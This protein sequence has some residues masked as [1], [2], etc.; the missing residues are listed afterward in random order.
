MDVIDWFASRLLEVFDQLNS[1]RFAN[2]QLGLL[3]LSFVF[4]SMVIS[5]FWRGARG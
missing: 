5:V 3:L 2:A 1:Y 4:L